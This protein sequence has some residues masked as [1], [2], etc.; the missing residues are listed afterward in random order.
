MLK[1][2]K[3]LFFGTGSLIIAGLISV[4]LKA[5]RVSMIISFGI[6]A[7]NSIS[8]VLVW[9][10]ILPGVSLILFGGTQVV[11]IA[12]KQSIETKLKKLSL[13]YRAKSSGQ[14]EVRE[15]LLVMKIDRPKLQAEIDDCLEQLNSIN[16]KYG[17][18]DQLIKS[19]DADAVSDSRIGL[20][21][22]EQTLV[23]NFKWVINTSI[24][25]DED[26]SSDTDTF[27]D[28]CRKRIQQVLNANSKA[29][30]KG[31]QFLLDIAD[32]I[33]QIETGNTTMLDAWLKTIRD[34]NKK[35]LIGIGGELNEKNN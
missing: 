3:L 26:S 30:D 9:T 35:S 29:L 16:R 28:Q 20:V 5:I 17:R 25:A 10:F 27:Y 6:V 21:E 13:D 2:I 32:N 19:N 24:A 12:I 7:T 22:I 34:Q 18:F 1:K 8:T 23:T 4:F 11:R 31:S 15:Q 14:E 33:S